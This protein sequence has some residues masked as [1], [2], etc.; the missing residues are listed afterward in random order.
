MNFV[1]SVAEWTDP[2]RRG[3]LEPIG[4]IV[5]CRP[6]VVPGALVDQ[7]GPLRHDAFG[8]R[9]FVSRVGA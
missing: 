7:E 2:L 5:R 6:S 8:V 4:Q 9:R 1:S 3:R